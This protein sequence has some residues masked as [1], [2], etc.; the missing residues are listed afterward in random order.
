MSWLLRGAALARPGQ[1]WGLLA[2]SHLPRPLHL[3]FTSPSLFTLWTSTYSP[4]CTFLGQRPCSAPMPPSLSL[5]LGLSSSVPAHCG[6]P[7]GRRR[8]LSSVWLEWNLSDPGTVFLLSLTNPHSELWQALLASC[9]SLFFPSVPKASQSL[10]LLYLF[11][12][13]F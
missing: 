11:Y 3:P 8:S 1:S 5:R 13:Y 10:A 7:V 2:T 6:R 9:P 12:F 4:L